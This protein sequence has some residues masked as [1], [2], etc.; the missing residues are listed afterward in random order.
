MR[1][2]CGRGWRR[3][4]C[5]PASRP[6]F[7]TR[8]WRSGRVTPFSLA[9]LVPLVLILMT[10]TGAVYPAIDLTAGERER[11]TLET[12]IA[13]PISRMALLL[14]KYI[15]VLT[16]AV[17]TAMVNLVAMTV[18]IMSSSLHEQ[19][20]PDGL[21]I[22]LMVE[23]FGLMVLFAAFFSAILLA[24]TSFA[25][26]FKEAQAYLIPVMLL[27]ISPGLLSLMPGLQL[28]GLLAVAPLVN[29]VLL[30]RDLLEAST[31][32]G[33]AALAIVSTVVYAVGAL[34]LASKVF[35]NDALLYAS[36]GSWS[37]LFRRPAGVASRADSRRDGG[38]PGQHVP[39]LLPV[40]E[41]SPPA[42]RG[43]VGVQLVLYAAVSVVVFAVCPLAFAAAQRVRL[44]GGLPV[45]VGPAAELPGCG[46][47]G[48][49]HCGRLPTNCFSSASSPD[50]PPWIATSSRKSNG[51]CAQFEACRPHWSW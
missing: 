6:P 14:A 36:R 19:L 25:R 44:A 37:D 16:V 43:N 49:S 18:T 9:T 34:L 42:A 2:R 40:A 12:L 31:T 26:S 39:L 3:P 27:A 35:G 5:G 4:S 21:S 38:L 30:S 29:I 20:F 41:T 15:A 7:P 11:G 48:L 45:C 10:I 33:M 51:C 22:T 13:A 46:P 23:I 17:L 47:V 32:P 8:R 28:T 1:P 24:L 50:W